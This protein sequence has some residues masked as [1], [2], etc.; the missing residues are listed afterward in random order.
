MSTIF[1]LTKDS[2]FIIHH[3]SQKRNN[4]SLG[5]EGTFKKSPQ[6]P[7]SEDQPAWR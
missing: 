1:L 5:E 6:S 7:R 4:V 3:L 2:K